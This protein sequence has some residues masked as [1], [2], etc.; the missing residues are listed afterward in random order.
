MSSQSSSMVE[1]MKCNISVHPPTSTYPE[2]FIPFSLQKKAADG[3]SCGLPL[4]WC[5]AGG[6]CQRTS[7]RDGN[8]VFRDGKLWLGTHFA[9][10]RCNLCTSGQSNPPSKSCQSSG[11]SLQLF[12]PPQVFWGL[13]MN[14][15]M[16]NAWN[17]EKWITGCLISAWRPVGILKPSQL[18][19]ECNL[20]QYKTDR[21]DGAD[22]INY[23]G[24]TFLPP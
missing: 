19:T 8:C 23:G 2:S 16:C 4:L 11:L 9:C 21:W 3:R 17:G 15:L 12:P 20:W 1:K 6:C 22:L 13:W 18:I 5:W 7:V 14:N 24:D 10:K